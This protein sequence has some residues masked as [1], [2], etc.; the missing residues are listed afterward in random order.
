VQNV[1]KEFKWSRHIFRTTKDFVYFLAN[2]NYATIGF[3][4]DIQKI[5][6]AN[7]IFEGTSKTMRHI[8]V[9]KSSKY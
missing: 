2:K 3:T 4:K 9:K 8:K 6:D 1:V 7:K 5:D